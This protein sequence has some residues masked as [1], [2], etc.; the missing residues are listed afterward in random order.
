MATLNPFSNWNTRT[1]TWASTSTFTVSDTVENQELFKKGRP[2]R[3]KVNSVATDRF[4]MV[5]GYTTGTV[6]IS[7]Y[8]LTAS[9]QE[10]N[11]GNFSQICQ[12]TVVING[13]FSAS[14]SNQLILDYLSSYLKWEM[15]K[16]HIVQVEMINVTAE[17][18]ATKP[19][20]NI[21][22]VATAQNILSTGTTL[23]AAT[24][25]YSSGILIE[26]AVGTYYDVNYGD[27]IELACTTA[28][29]NGTALDLTVVINFVLE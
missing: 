16:A 2:L 7:G 1:V 28:G 6:T 27:T 15:T 22:N 10:M 3:Y 9:I 14:T 12:E 5:S 11:V 19:V 8:P 17:T 18:G 13:S 23:T 4:G 25:W 29:T 21:R 24:T 20:L 26:T